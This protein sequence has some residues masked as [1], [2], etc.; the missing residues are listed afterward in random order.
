MIRFWMVAI[1]LVG[2]TSGESE[3]RGRNR[4]MRYQGGSMQYQSSTR[5]STGTTQAVYSQSSQNGS[6]PVV[7]TA[8][9]SS[10]SSTSST[11]SF[12]GNSLQAWA[13]EEARLMAARGTCGHIRP[14]PPGCFV[15]VGCGMTCMGSGR[16]V[17]EASC[18][19]KMVRVWQR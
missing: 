10:T 19:G 7:Q 6:R 18:Q 16:L 17:A 13:E 11:S 12:Q 1:L 9:F 4:G 15:G 14:A 8:G 2:L 5:Y 3:A